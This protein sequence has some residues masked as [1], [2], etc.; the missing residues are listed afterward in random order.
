MKKLFTYSFAAALLSAAALSASAEPVELFSF[1]VDRAAEGTDYTIE[2]SS[3]SGLQV[4]VDWG[5]GELSNPVT[6]GDYDVTWGMT[7][8]SGK[9]AGSK[10][11]VYGEN[12]AA[13]NYVELTYNQAYG[14]DAKLKSFDASKL[15]GVIELT[16]SSNNI[17]SLDVSN[18][19]SLVR[20]YVNNNALTS[21]TLPE[22]E[23]LVTV[24]AG[25]TVNTT[26]G[27]VTQGSNQVL[28]TDWSK[29]PNLGTLTLNGN[30]YKNYSG[31][32]PDELDVSKNTKLTTLN[33]N[34]CNLP[35]VDITNC[36]LLKT[37]NAQ[38][39]EFTTIDLSKLDLA[40]SGDAKVI[41]MLNHNNLSSIKL[42]DTSTNRLMRLNLS[43]NAF[44]FNTLPATTCVKS[45]ANYV[46]SPQ[47]EIKNT[48]SAQNKV[49]FTKYAKVGDT[50]SEFTW[51]AI[52]DGATKPTE[53]STSAAQYDEIEPGLFRFDVPVKDLVGE[54]TNDVYPKLTL[55]TTPATSLG[56]LEA[57]VTIDVTSS[58]GADGINIGL[59]D[60][61][62][63][64]VYVDWG[65]GEFTGPYE[66][67][68]GDFD[69][70][71]TGIGVV[72]QGWDDILP[73]V[74]GSKIVVKGN[75]ATIVTLTVDGTYG[76]SDGKAT[77]AQA[78]NIDF[79]ALTG[80]KKLSLNNNLLTAVNLSTA[81]ELVKLSLQANKLTA[82]DAQ[83][84]NLTHLNI[85]N[86][87]SGSEKTFGDNAIATLDFGK[88]PALQDLTANFC[89]LNPDLTNATN[90]NSL[91]LI[92]NGLTTFAPVSSKLDYLS[93]NYNELTDFDGSGITSPSV[94]VFLLNNKLGAAP[95]KLPAGANNVN[96]NN[97]AF[98][99]ATLPAVNSVKGTLT[100]N[101]QAP[102]EV[103]EVDGK[104]DLSAQATV[105][106]TATVFTWADSEGTAIAAD[107]YTAANGVFTFNKAY[108]GAVCSM[109]NAAFE[110]LTLVTVPVDITA[111]DSAVAEIEAAENGE[112]VYYN[113]QGVKV[114]GNE[115]GLYIRRQGNKT[116]KVIIK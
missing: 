113:L 63:Q 28:G 81:P 105:G 92:G 24:D 104:I 48:L 60:I 77:S 52:L 75:P 46:Y 21:L 23:V 38:W 2:L 9:I 12:P 111:A 4:Q 14:E 97:N 65:D 71:A 96:V 66:I 11:I 91:Y 106:D 58:E 100:Y 5:N 34:C 10:I 86:Q 116:E 39:N 99:F 115:P 109:T 22:S 103:A 95:I 61:N 114:S 53:L 7:P 43:Y 16:L 76:W 84:A 101:L 98:T 30:D 69:S 89:G 55:T 88:L 112:A 74:K 107:D 31:W 90:L 83:L 8:V 82:F 40:T 64:D 57:I 70:G 108:T 51:S 102:V 56:L 33:L 37:F 49:D 78:T 85:S 1:V 13:L 27:L 73:S 36:T 35:E 15:T 17:Q 29:C 72:T 6:L 18:C 62:G 80:L 47:A 59:I 45:A 93:L 26:E 25:N 19:S 3:P 54:I 87:Y 20:L 67:A 50:L 79:S 94:N 44:D 42:P 110:K 41:A 68:A 32:W